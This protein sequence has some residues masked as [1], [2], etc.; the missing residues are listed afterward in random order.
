LHTDEYVG[1]EKVKSAKYYYNVENN[2]E[3]TETKGK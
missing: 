3:E 2:T 1:K